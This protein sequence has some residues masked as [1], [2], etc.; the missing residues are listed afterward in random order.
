LVTA[1]ADMPDSRRGHTV[2][3]PVLSAVMPRTVI[4]R[5]NFEELESSAALDNFPHR[6]DF[7]ASRK[8]GV[9]LPITPLTPADI[10]SD[11]IEGMGFQD[12]LANIQT[13]REELK[14]QIAELNHR[15]SHTI[16][17]SNPSL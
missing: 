1:L 10:A 12:L 17:Q 11:C 2:E 16:S 14:S 13:M 7:K 4:A 6:G 9:F 8:S 5:L 3:R 15:V